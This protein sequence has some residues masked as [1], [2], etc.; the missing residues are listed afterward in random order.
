MAQE[1][2]EVGICRWVTDAAA[3]LLAAPLVSISLNPAKR[4]SPMAVYGNLR[5]SPLPTALVEDLAK[6]SA[7]EWSSSHRGGSAAVLPAEELPS[8]LTGVGIGH[9]ARMNVRKIQQDLGILMVGWES[10]REIGPRE[11]FVFSTL[12]NQAAVALDNARLRRESDE[13]AERLASFNR[14]VQ[15]ITSSLDLPG[16]FRLVSSEAQALVSHDRASVALTDPDGLTATVYGVAGQ[17]ATLGAGTVV[18]IKGSSIG[19]AIAT[20][21]G[22][23]IADL[24]QSEVGSVDR[25]L[26]AM[27]IRSTVIVPLRG[28]DGCFGCLN[29][30]S[31]QVEFYGPD[32]LAL[33]QEIADEV[34]VAIINARLHE[35]LQ[36]TNE[37]LQMLIKASPLAVIAHD[38]DANVQ[39]WNPAAER[40]FGW[41][42]QEV[43]GHPYPLVPEDKQDEFRANLKR[44]LRGEALAGQETRRLNKDGTLIDVG[45]WTGPLVDGGAIIIVA[46]ITERKRAQE[47]LL[48]QMQDLA[49]LDERNRLA[50]EIHD[51]L[52]QEFTAIIWQVNAAEGTMEGKQ[53]SESLGRVRDLA[54]EGLAEARRSVW[55]LRAGILEGRTLGQGLQQEMEKVTEGGEIQTSFDLSGEERAL[56][57]GLEG[58][59]LRICQESLANVLKHANATQVKLALSYDDSQVRLAIRDNGVGFDP[60]TPKT[61]GRDSGGFNMRERARLLGGELTA[62]SEPGHGTLVEAILPLN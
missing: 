27:G 7:R 43:L 10:Y 41:S 6:L 1:Q 15:A 18:P 33:A 19:Q 39:I 52:A 34:A 12:A 51:S 28:G 62:Q 24:E 30:G 16:V 13:R 22:Y 8:T 37:T 29:F 54:K 20:G 59:L 11:Q 53:V 26:L 58:A 35:A 40:I 57:P 17:T 3:S 50:R 47:I 31:F 9:L 2:D 45:I 49:V 23:I 60:A 21:R 5:D 25:Q 46:D 56:T 61:R 38:I 44:S 32:E 36:E 42:E 55:D 48:Q 14:I 4:N